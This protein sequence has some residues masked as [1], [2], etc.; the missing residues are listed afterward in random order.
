MNRAA[1]RR[2]ILGGAA[3]VGAGLLVAACG[4]GA[5]GQPQPPAAGVQRGPLVFMSWTDLTQAETQAY[6]T[7]LEQEYATRFP[8]GSFK[9]EITPFDEYPTK[10]TVMAAAGTVPDVMSTSNAW[11]RDF[12]AMNG[13]TPLDEY[14]KRTP[15]VAYDKFVPASAFYGIRQGKIAGI[16]TGGPDSE[17]TLINTAYFREAGLDPSHDKLKTWTWEDF[18]AAAEKLTVRQ[19]NEVVRAGYQVKI[20]DGRHLAVWMYSQG[21][22][23][24][25]KDYT[26]LEV[27]NE[28][29]VRV[30]EHLLLLLNG[31][32]TSGPL[33]ASLD[34]FL[35][36]KAAMVQGGNWNANDIRRRNPQFEFDMFAYPRHPRG[37]KYATATWVNMTTIPRGTKRLEQAW[38][39]VAWHAGLPMVLKRLEMLKSFSPR[40]DFWETPQWKQVVNEFPQLQRTLDA[41]SVGGERPGLRFDQ[42]EAAMKPVFTQVMQGEISPRAAVAQLEEVARPLLAELPP[43]AR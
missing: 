11:M 9:H 32:R 13:L 39:Y 17:T 8:G 1:I 25:N 29:G 10:F 43:A 37:G 27:N 5:G 24:Y 38:E 16:P 26:G 34:G 31:K 28:Q 20:P 33:G 40:L 14:V 35:A 15:E 23:L 36:G 30:F 7:W 22:R 6:Y 12:W 21:G 42:M 2:A 3:S 18:D 41:A 19:G 4:R